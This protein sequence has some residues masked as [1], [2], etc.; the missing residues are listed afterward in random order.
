MN[1]QAEWAA[2]F[3]VCAVGT[4][5]FDRFEIETPA[6]KKLIRWGLAAVI[7]IG[8]TPVFGHGALLVLACVASLGAGVHVWWCARHGIHPL[9]ATPRR[10]Y[11]ELRG[12]S[13]PD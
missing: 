5:L 1:T 8:T 10:R 12:W 2:L 6:W 11:Y 13:W 7:T 4:S 3:V 9:R